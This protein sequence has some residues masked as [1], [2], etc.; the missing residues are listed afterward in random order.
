MNCRDDI[1][2]AESESKV[3]IKGL[4]WWRYNGVGNIFLEHFHPSV[5]TEHSLNVSFLTI[6]AD[7]IHSLITIVYPSSDGRYTFWYTMPAITVYQKVLA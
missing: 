1:Q 6:V 4:G 7:H 2:N 3:F 5:P